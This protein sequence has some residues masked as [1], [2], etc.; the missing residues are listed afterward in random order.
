MIKRTFNIPKYNWDV[1]IYFDYVCDYKDIVL[2]NLEELDMSDS[3]FDR[4]CDNL[5]AC[6]LDTGLTYSSYIHERSVIVIGRTSSAKEFMKTF[7][8]EIGHLKSNICEY[9][10]IPQTGEEIQYLGHTIIDE[11]WDI[12]KEFLCDCCRSRSHEEEYE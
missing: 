6:L 2:S 8:H 11:T 10:D 5:S 7:D 3:S 4:A 1:E 9:Y 12:A